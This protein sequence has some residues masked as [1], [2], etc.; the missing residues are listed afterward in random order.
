MALHDSPTRPDPGDVLLLLAAIIF[1]VLAP[2]LPARLKAGDDKTLAT[3]ASPP[4]DAVTSEFPTVT[5]P[6]EQ[7]AERPDGQIPAATVP[8]ADGHPDRIDKG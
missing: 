8:S 7:P 4:G 2:V 3:A 5:A 1:A 6:P